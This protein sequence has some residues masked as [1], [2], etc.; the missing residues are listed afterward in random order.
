MVKNVV[1]S[2]RI[3]GAIAILIFIN[4]RIFSTLLWGNDNK[5]SNIYKIGEIGKNVLYEHKEL[6]YCISGICC[7]EL[8]NI[9]VIDTGYNK[10]FK[11]TPDGKII[12]AFG[13]EGQNYGQ[14]LGS[15]RLDQRLRMSMGN[16]DKLYIMD[17]G[18]KRILVY[19]CSGEIINQRNYQSDF[20]LDIPAVNKR[21]DVYILS[22]NGMKLIDKFNSHFK[23]ETSIFEFSKHYQ[24][25][26]EMPL[27]PKQI[28]RFPND[29]D[30]IKLIS[31]NDLLVVISNYSLKAYVYNNENKLIN[32]FSLL[33]NSFKTDF[34]KK[35]DK[36]KEVNN[37][38]AY[39]SKG[40]SK[41]FVGSFIAPFK[42]F[43]DKN[44]YICL[45]YS[46][47]DNKTIL[48]KYGLDG[49]LNEEYV[50]NDLTEIGFITSNNEGDIII[51]RDNSTKIEI[52]RFKNNK[53]EVLK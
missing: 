18:N 36:L 6:F 45:A 40:T 33:T 42:A 47:N 4:L 49:K 19:S 29:M 43:I 13:H 32:E 44:N 20:V 7:D 50:F 52:Y 35:L 5:R 10:I 14:F 11:F 46:T 39:I 21:G 28:F 15:R 3:I 37:K 38:I 22:R 51:S 25:P 23:Y 1:N 2:K 30:I 27:I 34:T 8:N 53:E 12:G 48:T 17:G 41:R 24:F 26:I 9:Y 31:R 16:D